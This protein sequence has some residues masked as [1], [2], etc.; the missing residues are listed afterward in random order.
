M[1]GCISKAQGSESPQVTPAYLL[2]ASHNLLQP[3]CSVD[4]Q[5]AELLSCRAPARGFPQQKWQACRFPARPVLHIPLYNAP[6]FHRSAC[7]NNLSPLLVPLCKQTLQRAP[8]LDDRT[9][10]QAEQP[11]MSVKLSQE[12]LWIYAFCCNTDLH[13]TLVYTS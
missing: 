7:A 10:R 1:S 13:V 9:R 2:Y 6:I 3:S 4:V 8:C 12:L 5:S 11:A